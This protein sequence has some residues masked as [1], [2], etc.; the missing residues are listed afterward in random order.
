MNILNCESITEFL[1]KRGRIISWRFQTLKWKVS[2]KFKSSG[3]YTSC[4]QHQNK[5]MTST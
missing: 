1:R 5:R 2:V 3:L 4:D